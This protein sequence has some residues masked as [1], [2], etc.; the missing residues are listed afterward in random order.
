MLKNNNLLIFF[1]TT[2]KIMR[3]TLIG[4]ISIVCLTSETFRS[5]KIYWWTCNKI[6]TP[7][8]RRIPDAELAHNISIFLLKA[9]MGPIS[10]TK[11]PLLKTKV[12]GMNFEHP[13]GLAAGFDKQA[14]VPDALLE[15]RI[16]TILSY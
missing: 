10:R 11:Y 14:V 6:A 4:V 2:N 7:L 9:K 13:I 3:S 5:S 1:T 16:N 8:L 12:L 15:Y